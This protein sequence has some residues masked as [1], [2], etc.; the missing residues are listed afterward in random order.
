MLHQIPPRLKIREVVEITFVRGKGTK[1]FPLT[2]VK[3]Y[4]DAETSELLARRFMEDGNIVPMA[5][6]RTPQ[7]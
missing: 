2:E 7:E 1:I 3:E 5:D 6:L 4:Y